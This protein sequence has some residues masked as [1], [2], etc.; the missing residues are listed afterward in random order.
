MSVAER[1]QGANTVDAGKLSP[2]W[3]E[4]AARYRFAIPYIKEK[5][6]LD[7]ACGTGYGIGILKQYAKS[8]L[9]VDV[10]PE[11][12]RT[13]SME[14]SEN[15]HVI[16]GSGLKLPF[17][18]GYFDAVVSFE[19]L[20]HLHQR[21]LFLK[22]LHRVIKG[23]GS[24]ILSTPNAIYTKPVNGKPSNPFHIFEYT[25]EELTK[26]VVSLFAI[27]KFLGQ[28]LKQ[29]FG[30]PPFYEAQK[31]LPDDLT[32]QS[33][34]FVWKVVNKL[35]VHLRDGISQ[36]IWKCPFYPTENDYVFEADITNSAPV[37]VVVCRKSE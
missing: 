34:L 31:R 26:E 19:T 16:L 9:G 7:I 37:L 10:D 13:A 18:D 4:H 12:A 1:F 11:A 8:V 25:P 24:L 3:G 27:E 28:E 20:E 30:I 17:P 5:A 32:T 21:F 33:R 36:A 14:R 15:A 23:G 6:V 29:G 2:Y 22:E 35:P